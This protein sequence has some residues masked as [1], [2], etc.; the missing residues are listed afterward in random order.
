MSKIK[1]ILTSSVILLCIR[2][3]NFFGMSELRC[4]KC[5]NL[6]NHGEMFCSFCG[7]KLEDI[8]NKTKENQIPTQKSNERKEDLTGLDF[9]NKIKRDVKQSRERKE[10]LKLEKREKQRLLVIKASTLSIPLLSVLASMFGL[11][12]G[13]AFLVV[14]FLYWAIGGGKINNELIIGISLTVLFGI[15]ALVS[16]KFL[17]GAQKPKNDAFQIE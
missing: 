15:L 13:L 14:G 6:L 10:K 1:A 7:T 8:T 4:P 11:T 5:N 12:T 2:E 3:R 16:L 9:Y 17:H